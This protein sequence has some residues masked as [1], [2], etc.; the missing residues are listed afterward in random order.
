MKNRHVI[1]LVGAV[2]SG[3]GLIQ[4]TPSSAAT[5]C[6]N[7]VLVGDTIN[8]SMLITGPCIL[9][10]VTVKGSLTQ[11]SGATSLQAVN[12]TGGGVTLTGGT[13]LLAQTTI[14]GSLSQSGGQL[15]SYAS[16][17]KGSLTVSN[18][19]AGSSNEVC[20]GKIGGSVTVGDSSG[21]A[22]PEFFRLLGTGTTNIFNAPCSALTI[23]GGVTFKNNR[24]FTRLANAT[25][26]G[27]VSV[28]DN[29][30][31]DFTNEPGVGSS[32][33]AGNTIK[34]SLACTNNVPPPTPF[35]GPGMT[36]PNTAASKTGQC[37]AALGF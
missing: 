28:K 15:L 8:G 17:V 27:S 12:V 37:T 2:L 9:V 24:I 22:A 5:I 19:D 3:L 31:T 34:G 13:M 14:G 21:T 18:T 32:V 16:I 11:V 25:V 6:N 20:G 4:P 36:T 26:G 10:G 35:S 33:I 30:S 23:A 1:A 29:Q 7:N